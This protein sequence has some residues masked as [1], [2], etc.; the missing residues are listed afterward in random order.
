MSSA[1]KRVKFNENQNSY[2]KSNEQSDYDSNEDES[3]DE[4]NSKRNNKHSLDSDEEDNTEK[5]QILN[6]KV[7]SGMN[8]NL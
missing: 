2:K 8:N 5:Y 6:K 3:G 7:F 4:L 1:K